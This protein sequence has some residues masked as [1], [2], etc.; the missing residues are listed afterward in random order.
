MHPIQHPFHPFCCE[1]DSYF[2]SILVGNADVNCSQQ[3]ANAEWS[4]TFPQHI[5]QGLSRHRVSIE[6]VRHF[7]PYTK[8]NTI[9]LPMLVSALILTACPAA[10]GPAQPGAAPAEDTEAP[11]AE[12]AAGNGKPV[13]ISIWHG[14]QG[15]Y[16]TA[17]EE[18]FRAYEAEHPN[19]TFGL[20][21]PDNLSEAARVAIAP[22]GI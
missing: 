3:P 17:I 8:G 20:S 11:A 10:G 1:I 22:C 21:R 19:V 7:I 16:T 14:W 12:S 6:A 15:E 5:Q 2:H 13:T 18:A 9:A 4:D